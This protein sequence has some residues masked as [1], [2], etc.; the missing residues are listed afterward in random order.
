MVAE[1]DE[2]ITVPGAVAEASVVPVA[3]AVHEAEA[4]VFGHEHEHEKH[5]ISCRDTK[6]NTKNMK[7]SCSKN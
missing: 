7:F 1:R 5:E 6:K 3:V 4:I 2:P